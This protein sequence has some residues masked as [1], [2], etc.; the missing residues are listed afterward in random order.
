MRINEILIET[1]SDEGLASGLGTVAR[2]IGAIP[3]AIHGAWDAAKQGYQSGRAAVGGLSPDQQKA[4][5]ASKLRRQADELDGG[6]SSQYYSTPHPGAQGFRAPRV[7]QQ[8]APQSTGGQGRPYIAPPANAA[9]AGSPA[10]SAAPTT[11]APSSAPAAANTPVPPNNAQ[12]TPDDAGTGAASSN[13]VTNTPGGASNAASSGQQNT[14]PERAP[15]SGAA[16][17]KPNF[18]S[19]Q[20]QAPAASKVNYS[21]MPKPAPVATPAPAASKVN[22]S[23]MPKPAPVATPAAP[24]KSPVTGS[25]GGASNSMMN[26]KGAGVQNFS[27]LANMANK[28]AADLATQKAVANQPPIQKQTFAADKRTPAQIAKMKQ[29]GFREEVEFRS[30][31]LNMDI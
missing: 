13:T 5:K 26:L 25:S 6:N 11:P 27:Q 30:R 8:P 2:G 23:A 28:G 1:R 24:A 31:F 9:Q 14:P 10:D 3:G 18:S 21:A 19:G 20:T 22:Y 16:A 17:P 4:Q 7:S 12:A 15:A 29:A